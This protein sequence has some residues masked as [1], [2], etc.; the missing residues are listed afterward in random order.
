MAHHWFGRIMIVFFVS[1]ISAGGNIKMSWH[2]HQSKFHL[3]LQHP[4]A[5]FLATSYLIKN[6]K[7]WM[8]NE[9]EVCS[10]GT[11]YFSA[12]FF[13]QLIVPVAAEN[14]W[15]WRTA[16]GYK[17]L[18]ES[19]YLYATLVL[20]KP[21]LMMRLPCRDHLGS[22]KRREFWSIILFSNQQS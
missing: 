10:Y 22:K 16:A 17:A 9:I 15:Y 21:C 8:S 18:L 7:C 1:R 12:K 3:V 5:G 20:E 6:S 4:D 11:F 13:F 2:W 14:H 19:P